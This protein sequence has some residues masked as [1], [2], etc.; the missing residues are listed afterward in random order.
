[1]KDFKGSFH[2]PLPPL[3]QS[4]QSIETITQTASQNTSPLKIISNQTESK[5]MIPLKNVSH[6]DIQNFVKNHPD[7]VHKIKEEFLV[8]IPPLKTESKN[9]SYVQATPVPKETYSIFSS[10]STS[11]KRS[12]EQQNEA[13]STPKISLTAVK[14]KPKEI[15]YEIRQVPSLK[16]FENTK[17]NKNAFSKKAS[18]NDEEPI[19][20]HSSPD[21]IELLDSDDD[22][23]EFKKMK[24]SKQ[25]SI[26]ETTKSIER[27]DLTHEDDDADAKNE[28]VEEELDLNVSQGM[29]V[30]KKKKNKS[31]L[32]KLLIDS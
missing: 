26:L 13:S 14:T 25:N 11:K 2:P 20:I 9:V 6:A 19:I 22:E 17:T 12:R 31:N 18:R 24:Q 29:D 1:M 15:S 5:S 32:Q 8:S 3:S 27:L 21:T 23:Y 10:S 30:C 4:S 28:T 16:C 7:D